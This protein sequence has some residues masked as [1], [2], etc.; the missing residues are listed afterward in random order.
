[1]LAP[2][3]CQLS[4]RLADRTLQS[5]HDLLRRLGF[6]VKDR[7]GLTSITRLLAIITALS[8]CEEGGLLDF[9]TGVRRSEWYWGTRYICLFTLP[10]L[11]WVTLC[12]VCFLQSFP[13]Q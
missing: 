6:L 12:W 3:Q 5:Q 2:L 7:L 9:Y 10:A 11:Y 1:M 13:L 4:L 8:L